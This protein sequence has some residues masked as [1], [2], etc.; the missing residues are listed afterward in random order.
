[1]AILI[2]TLLTFLCDKKEKKAEINPM[3]DNVRFLA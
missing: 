2:L 3:S 1:M